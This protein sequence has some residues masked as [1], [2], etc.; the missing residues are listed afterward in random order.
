MRVIRASEIGSYLY[1]NRAWWYAKN[2]MESENAAEM[3][4]GDNFHH[5]HGLR[6]NAARLVRIGG[7]VLILAALLSFLMERF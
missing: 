6:V 3:L 7:I 2:G 4:A 1:C 5:K